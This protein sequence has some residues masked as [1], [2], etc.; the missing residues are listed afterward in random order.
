LIGKLQIVIIAGSFQAERAFCKW[1]F[2]ALDKALECLFL[3]FRSQWSGFVKH[4]TKFLK[5]YPFCRSAFLL[6]LPFKVLLPLLL[7]LRVYLAYSIL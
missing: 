2:I 1:V 4:F 3:W 6:R 5:Y 7:E